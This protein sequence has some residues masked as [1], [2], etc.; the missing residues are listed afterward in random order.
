MA[1]FDNT[2]RGALFSNDRKQTEK[3][4][5]FKG[6]VNVGGKEFWISGWKKTGSKGDFI[7]L[8]VEP[9]EASAGTP[10]PTAAAAAAKPSASKPAPGFSAMDE[11]PP[12]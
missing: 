11:T 6:T 12:F 8:S 2:N 4:P 1:D 9:K 10:A 3:H 5:D 7:S